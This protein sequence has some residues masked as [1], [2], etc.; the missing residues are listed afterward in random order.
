[1]TR[2]CASMAKDEVM[3]QLRMAGEGLC[4]GARYLLKCT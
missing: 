1:L 4:P 3:S 2:P